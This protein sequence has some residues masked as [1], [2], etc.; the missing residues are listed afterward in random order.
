MSLRGAK[1]VLLRTLTLYFVLVY[2]PFLL[3]FNP[4]AYK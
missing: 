1:R 3:D 4:I 2:A